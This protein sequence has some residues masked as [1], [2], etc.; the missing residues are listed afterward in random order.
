M[1]SSGS[2]DPLSPPFHFPGSKEPR[3]EVESGRDQGWKWKWNGIGKLENTS[4][5]G[6][7]NR[8]GEGWNR[9]HHHHRTDNAH[10]KA[11]THRI[12]P[13]SD[14]QGNGYQ[15][16]PVAKS[17]DTMQTRR[18]LGAQRRVKSANSVSRP[19]DGKSRGKGF[20]ARTASTPFTLIVGARASATCQPGQRRNVEAGEMH[21][22]DGQKTGHPGRVGENLAPTRSSTFSQSFAAPAKKPVAALPQD[23]GSKFWRRP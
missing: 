2:R 3:M 9:P 7:Q 18:R 20:R 16:V 8:A 17:A 1:T 14:G 19:H 15:R 13:V 11:P 5:I 10:A 22:V 4:T 21:G 12:M 6:V 23:Q